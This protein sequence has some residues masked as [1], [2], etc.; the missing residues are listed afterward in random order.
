M[1]WFRRPSSQPLW[2]DEFS[3]LTADER[4]V[5]RRQLTK[6]LTLTSLGMLVG[7]LWILVRSWLYRAPVY[8]ATPVA[9]LDEVPVGSIKIFSYPGP[10]EACILVRTSAESWVA[11]SQKC[12]H[13]SCAVYYA[14]QANRLECPCHEGYFSLTDGH[15]LQG[16]P[17]RPLPRVLLERRGEALVAVGMDL[18]DKEA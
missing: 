5:N 13:L 12:T 18:G 15:V 14:R 3:I 8:P 17:R 2:K 10:R 1:P 7:N 11:Y 9:R 4:Y 6:F 16:P